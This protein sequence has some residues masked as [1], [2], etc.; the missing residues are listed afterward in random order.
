MTKLSEKMIERA[1]TI[2]EAGSL[3]KALSTD[4]IPQLIECT[5]SEGLVL[6]LLKQ[7]VNK[8]LAI[9]GHGSTD[10]GEV[11]RVYQEAGVIQTFNFRNEIAMAHA[12]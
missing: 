6:G 1:K 4:I 8:Y 5:L 11:L 9:F 12:A 10:I 3:Q 7:G 2:A